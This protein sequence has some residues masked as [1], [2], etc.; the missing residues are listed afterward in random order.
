MS[1][2]TSDTHMKLRYQPDRHLGDSVHSRDTLNGHLDSTAHPD[3]EK[4]GNETTGFGLLTRIVCKQR[5]LEGR[6]TRRP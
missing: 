5:K 3:R 4:V 6:R 2:S 1:Q